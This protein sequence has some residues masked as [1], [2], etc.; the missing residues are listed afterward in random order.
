MASYQYQARDGRGEVVGGVI[1]APSIAEASQMLRAEGKYI[2]R[3]SEA[4]A[5]DAQAA[6][7]A[8]PQVHARRVSR[9]DV[10]FFAHQMAVMIE[11]GVPLSEALDCVGEQAPNPHFREVM[12]D[13]AA[14]VRSGGEFSAALRRYP[15]VFPTVMVSLL[16]ASEVSGT[17]GKMLDRISKY[18]AKEQKIV[19]QAR[20]AT[21]YP[22]FMVT[23][24]VG[25]TIFLMTFV[26][27]R[28]ASIYAAKGSALPGPTKLLMSASDLFVHHWKIILV[29]VT[30]MVIGIRLVL[31]TEAGSR[32][33][34]WLKLHL[35]IFR[36]L[37]TSLYV[38]RC[39]RTMGTMISAGVGMLD[40]VSIVR[41]V[42][43]NAYYRDLW[44]DVDHSIRQGAQLSDPLFKST[45]MPRTI[46]QMIRAGE[47]SGRLAD[48]LDRV[49][50][51]SEDEFDD[52]VKTTTQ[53]IEPVM[54]LFMGVMIGFVAIAL[55]LPI[56]SVGNVVAK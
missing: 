50:T 41:E 4:K 42:V 10:I 39:C 51:F 25:V 27:P 56:F 36:H 1:A 5:Q 35:P 47:K 52:A 43:P 26:L 19:R 17:M 30:A 40:T 29:V 44:A 21:A 46:V 20:G 2:V 13:I 28:F 48:V 34:D 32:G 45:L 49:A 8:T 22:L 11:T 14:S 54:V 15:G 37:F 55:L 12:R 7:A 6:A 9:N 53:F 18:L 23:V 3:L 31:R 24:A 16:R 33:A 38:A